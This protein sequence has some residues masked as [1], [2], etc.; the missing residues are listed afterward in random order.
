M[1]DQCHCVGDDKW[2]KMEVRGRDGRCPMEEDKKSTLAI[3]KMEDGDGE[4]GHAPG[5]ATG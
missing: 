5:R 2:G 4:D 1:E 3:G